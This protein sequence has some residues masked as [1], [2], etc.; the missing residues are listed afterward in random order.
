MKFS[1]L[2]P[3]RN[4]QE[5]ITLAVEA[6]L[7]QTY[8]DWELLIGNAGVPLVLPADD[9]IDCLNRPCTEPEAL[10]L[11]IRR[12]TGDVFVVAND[13]DRLTPD[14]LQ[15]VSEQL[16]ERDWLV[17]RILYGNQLYGQPGRGFRDLLFGNYI[18]QP[19][20]FWTRRAQVAVGEFDETNLYACDYEYWLRLSRY[21]DPF[22]V[23]HVMSRYSMHGQQNTVTHLAEQVRDASI[24]RR[25]HGGQ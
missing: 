5:F 12:A 7:A 2:M 13:D 3:T 24:A 10:N 25:K 14:A 19:A 11:G 4:R 22:H 9:R 16:Q 15:F 21:C 6:V 17:G 1:I 8:Q 18:P 23:E 20:S